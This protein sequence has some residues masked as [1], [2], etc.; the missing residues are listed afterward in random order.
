MEKPGAWPS[1]IDGNILRNAFSTLSRIKIARSPKP[2]NCTV[3]NRCNLGGTDCNRHSCLCRCGAS[4]LPP[5][6]D[7]ETFIFFTHPQGRISLVSG[8]KNCSTNDSKFQIS[9]IKFRSYHKNFSQLDPYPITPQSADVNSLVNGFG[10]A[11]YSVASDNTFV[12]FYDLAAKAVF[13]IDLNIASVE[14]HRSPCIQITESNPNVQYGDFDI[15]CSK[16]FVVAI[17]EEQKDNQTLNS[18]VL[19]NLTC[20]KQEPI[21]LASGND[22]YTY[23]RWNRTGSS[24]A[25]ITWNFPNMPWTQSKLVVAHFDFCKC[26]IT[27]ETELHNEGDSSVSQPRWAPDCENIL[28]YVC[29]VTGYY[30]LYRYDTKTQHDMLLLERPISSCFAY[31]D[32]ELGNQT[33]AI[34]P[35]GSYLVASH[36]DKFGNQ[37]FSKIN[38]Q[39]QRKVSIASPFTCIS[40]VVGVVNTRSSDGAERDLVVVHAFSLY[41]G[42][43][44]IW[45]YDLFTGAVDLLLG[46]EEVRFDPSYFSSPQTIVIPLDDSIEEDYTLNP[47]YEAASSQNS[48]FISTYYYPPSNPKYKVPPNNQPPLL[49]QVH[50]GPTS[51]SKP[52]QSIW[53]SYWTSRG[54]AVITPNYRGSFGFGRS[55]QRELE[56]QWGVLDV[57]DV[58]RCANFF[59]EKGLVDR[60][61]I[62]IDGES[63]GGFTVLRALTYPDDS[64]RNMFAAG[65]SYYGISNFLER[66]HKPTKFELHYTELLFGGSERK[67][68][69]VYKE[70]SPITHAE[71][72]SAP[73]IMFHGD[74]DIIV[75]KTQSELMRDAVKKHSK[76]PV[77][78][79]LIKGA[80]HG[81][82][83]V[84]QKSL[85]LE[86]EYRFFYDNVLNV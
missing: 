46:N 75:D 23:P 41:S 28:Y 69:N 16:Q 4:I 19:L 48:G 58:V 44:G 22:F 21:T 24:L 55:F 79:I 76:K 73:L 45:T 74:K 38:P 31:P 35:S 1:P 26:Q 63:A 2:L 11:S 42:I 25:Y 77:E 6:C 66:V 39:T 18:L 65:A 13:K 86:T 30:N 82:V 37:C 60:N 52:V 51:L 47:P 70:R 34:H 85:A 17:K 8:D 78:Y 83:S 71:R 3:C 68:P 84:E 7:L 14:L 36:L 15:H 43:V 80:G 9:E 62:C 81:F 50:G 67:L 33:Y 12:I 10:G 56:G 29:D 53:T 72:L 32:F 61:K 59:V 64:V 20:E 49:I 57:L 27:G 40:E 5:S 54:W